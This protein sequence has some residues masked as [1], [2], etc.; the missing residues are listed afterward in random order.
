MIDVVLPAPGRYGALRVDQGAALSV[1]LYRQQLTFPA[2][3]PWTRL[4]EGNTLWMSDTPQERLMMVRGTT[5]MYGHVL[6]AGG[7]LGLYPQYLRYYQPVDQITIVERHADV[8]ELLQTT[9]AADPGTEIVHASF[10]QF[11]FEQRSLTFDSCYIDIHPTL[12]PRWMAGMNWL[13]DQCAAI[14]TGPLRIWGYQWMARELV[15]GLE[16]EYIPLLRRNLH[17]DNRLGR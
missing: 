10:E 15:K 8:V 16:R 13:R 5:G 2:P 1:P 11:I 6:V 14:V 9:L 3:M 12:D 4:Y 7:G 17:F